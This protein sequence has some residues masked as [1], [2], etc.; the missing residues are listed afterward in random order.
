VADTALSVPTDEL[1]VGLLAFALLAA[2]WF[3]A[4]RD[5]VRRDDIGTGPKVVW[6]IVIVALMFVGV[7]L[8]FLFRPRGATGSER[9]AE[10]Q[11]SDEFVAK[12]SQPQPE[13]PADGGSVG[14]GGSA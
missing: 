9:A 5:L 3:L 2:A 10:Q 14:S 8:Y 1:L 12:Y 4:L 13:K 7:V 11:R 6:A